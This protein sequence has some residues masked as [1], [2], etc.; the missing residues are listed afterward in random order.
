MALSASSSIGARLHAGLLLALALSA[1]GCTSRQ[2]QPA[3]AAIAEVEAA[4]TTAGAAPIRYIP[5]EV[6]DVRNGLD[7]LKQMF[8]REDYADV[9]RHAPA[10][11]AAAQAL[12]QQATI[13]EAELLRSLGDQ[14]VALE[15]AVPVA[16]EAG[17][18][19]VKQLNS[20]EGLRGSESQEDETSAAR[21]LGDAAALWERALAERSAQH[22]PEAVT[23]GIQ[24]RELLDRT[25]AESGL[26]APRGHRFQ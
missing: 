19:R 4:L 10:V 15:S 9:L 2:M 6:G 14:W 13:R 22:L 26:G 1:T 23:L 24:A 7:G 8:E 3:Q 16:I 11:L 21:R 18:S 20:T 5:G 12:P 25:A 17:R